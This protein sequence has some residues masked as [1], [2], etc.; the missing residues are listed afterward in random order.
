MA[1]T[2]AE[3]RDKAS[4]HYRRSGSSL[5]RCGRCSMFELMGN[6]FDNNS[7]TEVKGP[8]DAYDVCDIFKARRG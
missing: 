5:R 1:K 8:I 3:K 2:E 6:K 4:V 7:C